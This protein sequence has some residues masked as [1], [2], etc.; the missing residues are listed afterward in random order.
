MNRIVR[1]KKLT[2]Y[3]IYK[4]CSQA[5]WIFRT[6]SSS[7]HNELVIKN[8]ILIDFHQIKENDFFFCVKL[9][10]GYM[11]VNKIQKYKIMW[12]HIDRSDYRVH[13]SN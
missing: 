4:H 8:E 2:D 12:K 10:K 6:S 13:I 3:L 7:N 11:P 1:T 5:V 9:I